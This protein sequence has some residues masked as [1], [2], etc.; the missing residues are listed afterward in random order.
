MT[1]REAIA[2]VL[3]GFETGVFVR[4]TEADDDAA[5]AMK[6][7]PY[8]H[9]LAVMS[10]ALKQADDPAAQWVTQ[11]EQAMQEDETKAGERLVEAPSPKHSGG[12][13]LLIQ[14]AK[15]LA[16][17]LRCRACGCL[18]DA[19]DRDRKSCTHCGASQREPAE[20]RPV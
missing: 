17:G 18:L 10:Q 7:L 1:L 9:A 4:S 2:K 6:L 19:H 12:I 3:E 16:K 15:D 8:I 13:D 11:N 20:G 14:A 5:W